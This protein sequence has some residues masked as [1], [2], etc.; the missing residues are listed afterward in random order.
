MVPPVTNPTALSAGSPSRS[1]TQAE[2]T[3]S[4]AVAAGVTVRNPAF[5]SHAPVSQSAASAAGWVPP[6]TNPK[7]RPDGIAGEPGPAGLG[8]QVHDRGR[9]RRALGEVATEPLGQVGHLEPGR[10]GAVGQAVQPVQGVGV[11]A[12]QRRRRGFVGHAVIFVPS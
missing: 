3:S 12:L 6:I 2:A 11:R 5:W 10:D 1:V 4:T 8:E 7:N 9:V